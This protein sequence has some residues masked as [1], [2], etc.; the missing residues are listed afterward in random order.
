MYNNTLTHVFIEPNSSLKT[1][2]REAFRESTLRYFEFINT[3]ETIN[4]YSFY[5]CKQLL[6]IKELP[7]SLV[8]MNYTFYGCKKMKDMIVYNK[9]D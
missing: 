4:Y 1:I 3:I 5:N 8:S 6:S 7:T 2:S 9:K